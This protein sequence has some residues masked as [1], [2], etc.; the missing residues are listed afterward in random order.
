MPMT[1]EQEL[2]DQK[3]SPEERTRKSELRQLQSVADARAVLSTPAGKRFFRWLFRVA[4][5]FDENYR[6]SA[7]TYYLLGRTSVSRD[8]FL[9][10]READPDLMAPPLLRED[11]DYGEPA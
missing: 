5:L 3:E 2:L 8:V 6:K 10:L 11:I 9:L 1:F 4:P 7:D